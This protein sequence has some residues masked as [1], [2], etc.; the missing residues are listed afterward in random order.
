MKSR[1]MEEDMA[2]N[3]HLWRLGVDGQL[4]ADIYIITYFH[5]LT[6]HSF[7]SRSLISM[8][9]KR[10]RTHVHITISSSKCAECV[11]KFVPYLFVTPGTVCQFYG[12]R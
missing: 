7:P 1:G 11:L 12:E 3:R 6:P 4:L 10:F 5:Y 2:E 9:I 8:E